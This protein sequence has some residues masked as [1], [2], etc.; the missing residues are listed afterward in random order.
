MVYFPSAQ[1]L[2][3]DRSVLMNKQE[4]Y[5]YLKASGINFE[6]TEH[7][8]VFTMEELAKIPMAHPE[9][10]AKNLFVR[11]EIGECTVGFLCRTNRSL[12]GYNRFVIFHSLTFAISVADYQEITT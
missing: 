5:E 7:E 8:A 1:I 12:F 2:F 4:I 3:V 9:A 6:V 10:E 11:D